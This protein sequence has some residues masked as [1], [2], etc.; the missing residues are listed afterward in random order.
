V[1][2]DPLQQFILTY[3][4]L[5]G[6]STLIGLS[7]RDRFELSGEELEKWLRRPDQAAEILMRNV[8]KDDDTSDE[9]E[10]E[11]LV[12]AIE[13]GKGSVTYK[14]QQTEMTLTYGEAVTPP[15]TPALDPETVSKALNIDIEKVDVKDLPQIDLLLGSFGFEERC[16]ASF[17]RLLKRGRFA[18]A[19]LVRF[20]ENPKQE[21]ISDT[22]RKYSVP[23]DELLAADI[24][25]WKGRN[26]Q[27][28]LVDVSG[29]HKPAIFH[30]CRQVLK[31]TGILYLCHTQAS[32]YYPSEQEVEPVLL[33]HEK[34]DVAALLEGVSKLFKGEDEPYRCE[35][36]TKEQSD[37]QRPRALIAFSSPKHE[38]LQALLDNRYYDYVAIGYPSN[39][40]SRARISKLAARF[41]VRN[42]NGTVSQ[43]VSSLSL[44]ENVKFQSYLYYDLYY[45]SGYNIELGLTGSKISAVT[46]AILASRWKLAQ[47]WYVKPAKFSVDRF[48]S[49]VGPTTLY[50]VNLNK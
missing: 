34:E 3:R 37:E 29:L 41:A 11:P 38:R 15:A 13:P 49:G 19:C 4:K 7:Y 48:T 14:G 33:A 10:E 8:A 36:L 30:L 45:R 32:E 31:S 46:A 9:G 25:R 17:Q 50:R 23:V 42:I 47:V 40:N 43:P 20:P 26:A 16:L 2:S 24:S 27:T 22:F 21:E 44:E 6:L 39:Q 1:D 12:T 18:R 5:Y 35:K 28:V